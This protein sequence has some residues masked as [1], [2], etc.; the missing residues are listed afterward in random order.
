M[1]R[2]QLTDLPPG[3]NSAETEAE[4]EFLDQFESLGE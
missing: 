4:S 1:L 3:S 2:E